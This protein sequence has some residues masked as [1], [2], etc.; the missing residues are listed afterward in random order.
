MIFTIIRIHTP[1]LSGFS[2]ITQKRFVACNFLYWQFVSMS[3]LN[4][5]APWVTDH[6]ETNSSW[7]MSL[8]AVSYA[9][10]TL[11]RNM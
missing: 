1:H 8:F 10:L 5:C 6:Q 7:L 9:T 11:D 2:P 3:N 4:L